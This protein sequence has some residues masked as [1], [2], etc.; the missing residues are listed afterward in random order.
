MADSKKYEL[1]VEGRN[2]QCIIASIGY[3]KEHKPDKDKYELKFGDNIV[4]IKYNKNNKNGSDDTAYMLLQ[5]A[6]TAPKQYGAIAIIVDA[7]A[8]K[9]KKA[10]D[11]LNRFITIVNK[12][13][14]SE[15]IYDTTISLK[16]EG[17]ILKPA[18]KFAG[19]FPKVG[20]WIMPDNQ[21]T[22]AIEHFLWR[23]GVKQDYTNTYNNVEKIVTE[24][25]KDQKQP[26]IMHYIPNHHHK[27]L[28]HTFLAW[29]ED[30]GNPMGQSVD[31][32]CWNIDSDLVNLFMNWLNN[33]YC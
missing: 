33:L 17:I 10:Q 7:D 26:P 32:K 23:C 21:N 1:Y 19:I 30:P 2:D 3:Q 16:N 11:R 29:V 9:N 4:V 6:L 15:I 22:G 12:V 13:N 25:E 20:L 31:K 14:D 28:V 27:A 18:D 24:F 8:L 5:D